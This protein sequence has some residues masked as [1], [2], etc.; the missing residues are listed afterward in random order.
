MKLGVEKF[1]VISSFVLSL[2]SL[3]V[4]IVCA[5]E[6]PDDVE[7]SVSYDSGVALTDEQL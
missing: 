4:S 2:L 6:Y 3:G 5:F 1:L 7:C